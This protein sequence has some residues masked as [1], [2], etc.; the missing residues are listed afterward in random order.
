MLIAMAPEQI[1]LFKVAIIE[2]GVAGHDPE[3]LQQQECF[4]SRSSSRTT[5]S[6]R[7]L[8]V[9]APASGSALEL[10]SVAAGVKNIS[11]TGALNRD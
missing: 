7:S 11:P 3:S 8:V 10:L 2:R 4:Q 5:I 1:V 6:R 9:D